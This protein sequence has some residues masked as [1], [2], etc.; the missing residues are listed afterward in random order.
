MDDNFPKFSL[1]SRARILYHGQKGYVMKHGAGDVV[2][3]TMD[4]PRM[5]LKIGASVNVS[6]IK[7]EEIY[8]ISFL[9]P[10]GKLEHLIVFGEWI[11]R[12]E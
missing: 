7:G 12:K 6:S 10:E 8:E 2:V 4:F 5:G 3:L 11:K 9:T 1:A